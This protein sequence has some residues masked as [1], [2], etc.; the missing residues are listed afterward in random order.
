VPEVSAA[1]LE[2]LDRIARYLV[3]APPS[4]P[5]QARKGKRID[6]RM[7]EMLEKDATRLGWS[8]E[9]W[10]K[11]LHCSKS[12]VADT[13]TWELIL[14]TRAMREAEK[15][16]RKD[17]EPADRRRFRKQRRNND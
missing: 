12:T 4:V 13:P 17:H 7:K 5:A 1:L 6:E 8:A 11:A 10:A 15:L 14:N 9:Q 16:R 2:K 3:A